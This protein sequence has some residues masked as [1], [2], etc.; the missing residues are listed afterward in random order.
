[1]Q[2]VECFFKIQDGFRVEYI[3]A[4]NCQ[5]TWQWADDGDWQVTVRVVDDELDDAI[6]TVNATVLNR[7][8][9]VNLTADV[10]IVQAGST[11]T[12]DASDSGDLDTISPPGQ[13]L[14]ITWPGTTC[15]DDIVFGPTCPVT[16]QEEGIFSME[17]VVTDDDGVSVSSF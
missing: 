2:N 10:L 5:T 15:N 13:E 8:P 9:Y 11:I 17:V 4:P 12:F 1:M 6:L 14:D 7:A 3:D 16:I